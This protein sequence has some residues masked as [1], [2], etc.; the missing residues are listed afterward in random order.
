[1]HMRKHATAIDVGPLTIEP[2]LLTV[3]IGDRASQ[4]T[5]RDMDVLM[6]LAA[7]EGRVLSREKLLQKVWQDVIV[8]DEAVSLSISRI[9]SALGESARN[10]VFIHTIPKKG[11]RLVAPE[12]TRRID[13]TRL[14]MATL[15]VL[16]ILISLL[17]AYVRVE[18]G[19]IT[20]S[21]ETAQTETARTATARTET[22]QS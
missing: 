12:P 18:Y 19:R 16:L 21:T 1:M 20:D 8:N 17:Y 7:A 5:A 22:V 3:T 9:R 2:D 6:C 4:L 13:R 11:Y 10:P 15:A 14:V